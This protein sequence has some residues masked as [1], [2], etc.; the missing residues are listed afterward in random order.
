MDNL[1][2]IK[3]QQSNHTHELTKKEHRTSEEKKY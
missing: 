3:Y 2:Y 1:L